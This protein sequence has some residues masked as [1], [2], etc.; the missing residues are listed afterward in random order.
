MML[1]MPPAIPEGLNPIEQIQTLLQLAMQYIKKI[2]MTTKMAKPEDLIG[3][4]NVS[5]YIGKL[6]QGMQG[7]TGN[8]SKMKQFAQALSQLNNEIKKLQQHLQMQMQ[9]QQQQNGSADIQQ[10]MM[11]TQA[12]I[13]AKN[14]ET[15]QKLKAKEL[16]DIQ[17]RRHKDAAFVG[18]QQRKDLGAVADTIRQSRKPLERE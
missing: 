9:K 17:K 10:S 3:L 14:A 11:E 4:Q 18:D 8:E 6:V 5:G 2:E 16:A 1:G 7:D 12:K 15:Q 13:A